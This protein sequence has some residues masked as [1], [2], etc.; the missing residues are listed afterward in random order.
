MTDKRIMG[1]ALVLLALSATSLLGQQAPRELTLEEAIVLAKAN[2]PAFLSTQNDQASAS[3]MVREAFA[4]FVPSVTT[5][6]SGTWME[7]G[8]QRF[9]TIVFE[10]QITDWH[11][12]VTTST[13][14]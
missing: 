8:T 12:R 10:D 5:N 11:S 13:S 1:A 3:W 6:A 14:G 4:Q 9:G 7:A 2:N